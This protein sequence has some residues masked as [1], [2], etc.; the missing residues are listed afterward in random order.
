MTARWGFANTAARRP[1]T[2]ANDSAEGSHEKAGG[3]GRGFLVAD[4]DP[5]ELLR[6]ANGIG[7]AVERVTRHTVNL[8]DTG[9]RKNFH[10]QVRGFFP[11][12]KI[13]PS[14]L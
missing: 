5:L 4:M 10:E 6:F 1:Q 8:A 9:F 13:L 14:G 2:V 3:E 11:S 12:H 7:D